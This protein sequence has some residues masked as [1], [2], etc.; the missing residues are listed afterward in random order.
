MKTVVI[1]TNNAHKASEIAAAL[2]FPS[3][4]FKTLD[5]MG[6]KSDPDETET[7]FEGNARIKA[8]LLLLGARAR[9]VLPR[10]RGRCA[11]CR[12]RR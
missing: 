7:T 5:D 8:C 1:A 4:E 11:R 12:P 3:W 2:P 10:F 9:C 6:I